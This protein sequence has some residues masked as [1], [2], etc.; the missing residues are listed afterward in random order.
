M[1]SY[2]KITGMLRENKQ[3]SMNMIE[4]TIAEVIT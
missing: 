2:H 3:H 4:K 1:I